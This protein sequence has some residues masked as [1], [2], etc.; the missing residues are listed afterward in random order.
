MIFRKLIKLF[1]FIIV[2]LL[3]VYERVFTN[4]LYTKKV[5]ALNLSTI[6]LDVCHFN[7]NDINRTLKMCLILSITHT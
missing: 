2:V 6:N 4:K 7:L 1:F 5:A 3:L